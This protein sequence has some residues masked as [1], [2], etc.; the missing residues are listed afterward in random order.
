[1]LGQTRL[2]T[3][4]IYLQATAEDLKEAMDRHPLSSGYAL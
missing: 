2:D 4:G 3:T 1:M